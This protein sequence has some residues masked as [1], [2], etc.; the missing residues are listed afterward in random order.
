VSGGDYVDA[1]IP[2]YVAGPMRTVTPNR[3]G[4]GCGRRRPAVVCGRFDVDKVLLSVHVLAA[5]VF[6]G[7][8]TVAVSLFPRYAR[9]ALADGDTGDDD[10][11]RV[12]LRSAA[13]AAVL[14]RIS[15]MYAV[16][17]LSVPVAGLALAVD[18]GVLG[19]AWLMASIAITAA[20][21]AILVFAVLPAQN[22]AMAAMA[23][24]GPDGEAARR[25]CLA[26]VGRMSGSA[27]MFALMWSIVV[28]LMV[29]RPGST[30]GV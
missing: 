4:R 11:G 9:E 5:I 30:T 16:L 26:A 2:E 8:V 24:A 15:R 14:H 6:I 10:A 21:A 13:V 22:R 27:G 7:P 20:A 12:A 19:D 25:T 1:L 23:A 17:G 28:V 18:M 3:Q 29:F